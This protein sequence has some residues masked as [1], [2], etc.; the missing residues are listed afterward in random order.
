[1]TGISVVIITLNEERNIARC[2][3]SVKNVADEIL[4]LDSFSNDKTEEI[5]RSKNVKFLQRKWEGYSS[6]KNF[7][8]QQ[9]NFDW[10]L[11]L[12]ADEALSG[13]LEKSI[14]AIKNN[15]KEDEVF[16][17]SRLANYCGKWI[18]HSGWYPDVKV[19]LFNRKHV[20]WQGEIHEILEIPDHFQRVQLKGDLLHYSYYTEEEHRKQADKFSSLGAT[21]LHSKGKSSSWILIYLKTAS[22]FIR[23]YIFKAGFLDGS[24]GFKICKITAWETYQKYYKLRNLNRST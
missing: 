11:S 9:A 7:A 8:N 4:V 21:S 2:I 5:C 23:N 22:K 20:K 12:D 17:F 3:D 10:I 19:R 6:S 24:A 14:S 18:Y 1:M 13:D 16:Q 15:L